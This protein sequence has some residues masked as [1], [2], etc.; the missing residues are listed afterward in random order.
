MYNE[1]LGFMQE[2]ITAHP[3]AMLMS[4]ADHECGGLTTNGFDPAA[5]V[6]VAHPFEYLEMQWGAYNESDKRGYF[7]STILPA[8][9]LGDATESQ[10]DTLL[11]A[12]SP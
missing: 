10:I 3:D 8:A 12:G 2:W 6:S 9:G 1:V 5:L 7:T 4:A 11:A